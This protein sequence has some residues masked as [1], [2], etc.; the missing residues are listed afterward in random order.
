MGQ[1]YAEDAGRASHW[2]ANRRLWFHE[3]REP[4]SMNLVCQIKTVRLVLGARG[5]VFSGQPG[6][7]LSTNT[8][9]SSLE[10]RQTRAYRALGV[11]LGG[12]R[13]W[14]ELDKHYGKVWVARTGLRRADGGG[15]PSGEPEV[16]P[17]SNTCRGGS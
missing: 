5:L 14:G 13:G 10:A 17:A 9:A 11:G 7:A 4:L 15:G 8:T 3:P 16:T 12:R 2:I 6:V 1:Q